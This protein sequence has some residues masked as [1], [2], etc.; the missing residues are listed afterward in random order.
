[1]WWDWDHPGHLHQGARF[2]YFFMSSANQMVVGTFIIT[3]EGSLQGHSMWTWLHSHQSAPQHE[4][5]LE[6]HLCYALSCWVML[7]SKYTL[8]AFLLLWH[9]PRQL[10]ISFS[11]SGARKKTLR[12]GTRLQLWLYKTKSG[13][14]SGSSVTFSRCVAVQAFHSS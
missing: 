1:M 3:A 8:D 12:S 10:M 7:T 9:L 11:N 2:L 4:S 5:S 14:E 13:R 6:L